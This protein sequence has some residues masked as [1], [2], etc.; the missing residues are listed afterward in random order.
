MRKPLFFLL[1]FLL[2]FTGC[3]NNKNKR[4]SYPQEV[5]KVK[6]D[7]IYLEVTATGAVKPQVGAEVKVGAR[8]S[9]KVEKLFVT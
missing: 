1:F 4:S 2:L 8:I 5:T 9:G 6:R 3:K 7:T